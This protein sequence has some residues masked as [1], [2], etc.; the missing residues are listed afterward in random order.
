MTKEQ[1]KNIKTGAFVDDLFNGIF[2]VIDVY[3][4]DGEKWFTCQE[5]YFDVEKKNGVRVAAVLK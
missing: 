1:F 4:L 2:K 5:V 3:E